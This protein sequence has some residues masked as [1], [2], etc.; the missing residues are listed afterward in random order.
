GLCRG[1]R[2]HGGAAARRGAAAPHRRH[3]GG[4]AGR[5]TRAQRAAWGAVTAVRHLPGCSV[6][7][8]PQPPAALRSLRRLAPALVLVTLLVPATGRAWPTLL[9][10]TPDNGRPFTV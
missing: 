8:R 1:R 4:G 3:A 7:P 9:P 10:D 6:P 2:A 5:R